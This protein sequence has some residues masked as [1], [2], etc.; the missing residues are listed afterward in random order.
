MVGRTILNMNNSDTLENKA[1]RTHDEQHSRV[2]RLD[3]LEIDELILQLRWICGIQDQINFANSV[4]LS[5]FRLKLKILPLQKSTSLG[6]R[7]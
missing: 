3:G 1:F 4:V 5:H 7:V 2:I 6:Y